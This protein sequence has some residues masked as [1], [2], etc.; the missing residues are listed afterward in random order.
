MNLETRS[1]NDERRLRLKKTKNW[2]YLV[3]LVHNNEKESG[4]EEISNTSVD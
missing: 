1:N 2:I 3:R 4:E